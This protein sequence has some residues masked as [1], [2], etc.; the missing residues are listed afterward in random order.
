MEKMVEK[1]VEKT[2]V[3][4][5]NWG[6]ERVISS[7][8]VFCNAYPEKWLR[9]IS[10][11]LLEPGGAADGDGAADVGRWCRCL[12]P[13]QVG[14]HTCVLC[15]GLGNSLGISKMTEPERSA[16]FKLLPLGEKAAGRFP[17]AAQGGPWWQPN[18]TNCSQITQ[19]AS[20]S[21]SLLQ[22]MGWDTNPDFGERKA[23]GPKAAAALCCHLPS[24]QPCLGHIHPGCAESPAWLIPKN[25]LEDA[26]PTKGMAET[27]RKAPVIL[28]CTCCH[29]NAAVLSSFSPQA[30]FRWL[31]EL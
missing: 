31:G 29:R 10:W 24:P 11:G 7:W 8:Q 2:K 9:Q 16:D 15:K 20:V 18:N 1:M 3:I 4:H 6:K 14:D 12:N 25:L 21:W 30:F 27:S 22:R 13:A 5:V 26:F 23:R 19:I 17:L 28:C